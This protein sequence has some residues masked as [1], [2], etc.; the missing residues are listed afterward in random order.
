MSNEDVQCPVCGYYCLGKGGVGCIDKPSMVTPDSPP[1]SP[2]PWEAVDAYIRSI[3]VCA[4]PNKVIKLIDAA[5]AADA[6]RHQQEIQTKND[7]LAEALKQAEWYRERMAEAN[8]GMT[9]MKAALSTAEAT[10]QQQTNDVAFLRAKLEEQRKFYDCEPWDSLR[11]AEATIASL[12]AERDRLS[13][14]ISKLGVTKDSPKEEGENAHADVN[15]G[16]LRAAYLASSGGRY[17]GPR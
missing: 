17:S 6:L 11:A 3:A 1:V 7:E 13:T 4:V 12:T 10:I 16:Q 8:D 2:D 9:Y 5:R 15:I 14:I